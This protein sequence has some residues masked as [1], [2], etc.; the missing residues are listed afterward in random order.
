MRPVNIQSLLS[1]KKLAEDKKISEKIWNDYLIYLYGSSKPPLKSHE[2]GSLKALVDFLNKGLDGFYL[3]YS[4]PQIGKEFDLLMLGEYKEEK[5]LINIELK[6]EADREAIKAQLL[7]NRYYLNFSHRKLLLFSFNESENILYKLEGE[8]LIEV[9]GGGSL[10]FLDNMKADMVTDLDSLF[11]PSNYLISPFNTTEE[12][13]KQE[14]FLNRKQE[15]IKKKILEFVDASNQD[16]ASITGAAGTGKTLLIYDIAM[17]LMKQ[18]KK[19]L[20]LHCASL[21]SGQKY[22]LESHNWDI[23]CARKVFPEELR[24]YDVVIIDEAQRIDPFQWES[25]KELKRK[26]ILSFDGK[27]C[28]SKKEKERSII[29][30]ILGL[31]SSCHY[32][33]TEKVRTNKEIAD[34]LKQLLDNRKNFSLDRG[35]KN[36]EVCH[37]NSEDD[38]ILFQR[39]RSESGWTIPRYTPSMYTPFYYEKYIMERCSD[40][41]TAHDIIGQEYDN[42][43]AIIDNTFKYNE[44]GVLVASPI[45]AKDTY[46]LERMFYQIVTRT[47]KK[48][49]IAILN[50]TQ[51]F[52]RCMDILNNIG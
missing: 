5:Y 2:W 41:L 34:F 20:I 50:N 47:R 26:C 28:L 36:I 21:N 17:T 51:I 39:I 29:L 48:L 45:N 8:N 4:I 3:G 12:F 9:K 6:R 37:F 1:I 43:L 32:E 30:E 52:S 42:V 31:S 13:V 38:I 18:K 46:S 11:D 16:L 19:V 40:N 44:D 25:V 22:L 24:K 27:Q 7:R 10:D 35:S 14:Y 15:E 49:C 33:L 23:K